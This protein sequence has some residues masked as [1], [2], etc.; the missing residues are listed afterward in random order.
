MKKRKLSRV[1]KSGKENSSSFKW[2]HQPCRFKMVDFVQR[3]EGGEEVNRSVTS[4]TSQGLK[5]A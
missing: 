3:L 5:E 2:G 4:E 1:M